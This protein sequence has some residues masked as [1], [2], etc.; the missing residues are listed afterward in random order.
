VNPVRNDSETMACAVCGNAFRRSGRRRHCSDAC[1]QAAWRRR[2][3]A[4]AEPVVAKPDTVY[5]CPNCEARFLAEQRCEECNKWARRLGPGGQ[6]PCC[7]EP[8]SVMD[9]LR[10]D[11][12][13]SRAGA[14]STGRRCRDEAE[15]GRRDPIHRY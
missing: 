11:Q 2:S 7:D 9:L 5:Q 8:I 4:S 10:P 3:Q 6:C 15:D 14:K 13:A 1:R 12:F